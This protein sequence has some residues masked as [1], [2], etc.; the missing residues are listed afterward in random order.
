ML[1]IA[2]QK[3][4]RLFDNSMELLQEIG[5]N[6]KGSKNALK[7]TAKNFPLEVLFLRNSD[8]PKYVESGIVDL[9]IL[10][11]NTL[12]EKEKDVK[13]L[14]KL[15]FSKCRLSLAVPNNTE[16]TDSSFFEGKRIA[17]SYTNTLKRFLNEKGINAEI[18]QISGS[19]EVAPSIGLAD[20][21]CDLVESGNTLF[22]NNMKEVEVILQSEA[23]L[24]VNNSVSTEKQVLID[25]IMFRMEATKKAKTNKYVVFNIPN[26]KIS[27]AEKT[28]PSIKSPTVVP[29]AK[30]GWSAMHS[31]LKEEDFWE[32]IDQLKNI[33]AEGI[34]VMPIEKM[35]L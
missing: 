11:K 21:I 27:E 29:L 22:M 20:G 12:I 33:G 18:H 24:I 13:I 19:V 26:D 2:I 1:R 9:G 34:L 15:G 31:V 10:G 17:T 7:S 23:V 30:K 8:I 14:M 25:K 16:Y 3:K 28:L 6:I 35:V 32:S 5:I 4:G